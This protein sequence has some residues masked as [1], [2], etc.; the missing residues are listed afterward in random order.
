MKIKAFVISI[1]FL[2]CFPS[3]G[4]AETELVMEKEVLNYS[5]MGIGDQACMELII[6]KE[7]RDVSDMRDEHCPLSEGKFSVTLSG[8]PGTTVTFFGRFGF[9]KGNGF[10]TIKK[11][12]DR[13]LWLWDLTDFPS[14]Q[15]HNSEANNKSGAFD[16]FYNA[17]PT[18]EQSVSSI[19]WGA[20]DQ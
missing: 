15:W 7:G 5:A 11:K 12:D 10:L 6:I 16:A 19:K 14:G 20:H 8:P 2:I 18:F 3:L 1:I 13:K 9:K 4:F 17:S